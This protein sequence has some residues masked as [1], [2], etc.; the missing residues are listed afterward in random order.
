M[1]ALSLPFARWLVAGSILA[2]SLRGAADGALYIA[3]ESAA[4]AASYGASWL[5]RWPLAAWLERRWRITHWILARMAGPALAGM[6]QARR[7]LLEAVAYTDFAHAVQVGIFLLGMGVLGAVTLPLR[8]RLD[9]I[10]TPARLNRAA[11]AFWGGMEAGILV[12][13]LMHRMRGI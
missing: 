3:A 1:A 4:A 7:H 12:F 11:G 9:H 10:S 5:W 6:S 13:L 2:G 8:T